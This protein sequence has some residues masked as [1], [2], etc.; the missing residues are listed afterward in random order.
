M[1]A[2]LKM[3]HSPAEQVAAASALISFLRKELKP[4]ITLTTYGGDELIVDF[5]FEDEKIKGLSLIGPVKTTFT[6]E[7]L[8]NKYL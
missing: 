4:P 3:K 5:K 2:G 1:S 8:L 6:G 7:F